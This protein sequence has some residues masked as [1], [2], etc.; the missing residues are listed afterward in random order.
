MKCPRAHLKSKVLL[1]C[2]QKKSCACLR[3]ANAASQLGNAD[4]ITWAGTKLRPETLTCFQL[5][6]SLPSIHPRWGKYISTTIPKATMLRDSLMNL[7]TSEL[8]RTVPSYPATRKPPLCK[9]SSSSQTRTNDCQ[10]TPT[11]HVTASRP[12]TPNPKP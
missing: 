3:K 6:T 9:P 7:E 4:S 11:P 10:E 5:H 1:L 12:Q 8:R 2:S